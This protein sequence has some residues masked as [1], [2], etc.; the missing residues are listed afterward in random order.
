[1]NDVLSWGVEDMAVEFKKM[2]A[3]IDTIG[4]SNILGEEESKRYNGDVYDPILRHR[5]LYSNEKQNE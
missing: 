5:P 1:M 2:K 4:E 3:I